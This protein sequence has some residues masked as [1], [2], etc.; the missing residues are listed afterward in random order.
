MAPKAT[1][2]PRIKPIDGGSERQLVTT[3]GED[4]SPTW[5][6][7]GRSVAFTRQHEGTRAIYTVSL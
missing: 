6:P 1:A 5:S 7:D 4:L 2:D 3:P